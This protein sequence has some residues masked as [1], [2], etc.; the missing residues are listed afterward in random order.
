[1][2]YSEFVLN[3]YYY[4][5]KTA[6]L[7]TP[8]SDRIPISTLEQGAGRRTPRSNSHA[9]SNA[10]VG[11]YLARPQCCNSSLLPGCHSL[12]TWS[13]L[14]RYLSSM[15]RLRAASR[16]GGVEEN[17]EESDAM[18]DFVDSGQVASRETCQLGRQ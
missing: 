7:A 18:T 8:S 17:A 14:F 9:R 16:S 12:H 2:T 4:A 1:M 11:V 3:W 10:A 6:R 15:T 5:W 13:M